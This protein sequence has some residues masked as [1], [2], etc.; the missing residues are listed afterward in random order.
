[1]I[2][3]N[4]QSKDI[5]GMFP[6]ISTREAFELTDIEILNQI[7]ITIDIDR[8]THKQL[9]KLFRIK[10]NLENRF[11]YSVIAIYWNATDLRALLRNE[12]NAIKAAN[13]RQHS[14]SG[15]RSGQLLKL[16]KHGRLVDTSLVATE[17]QSVE[18]PAI[19]PNELSNNANLENAVK[20]GLKVFLAALA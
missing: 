11:W 13:L 7:D 8:C 17:E 18:L 10:N 14:P 9:A 4:K 12:P 20:A 3:H 5:K 15:S 2:A 19:N 6:R 1:M 16:D